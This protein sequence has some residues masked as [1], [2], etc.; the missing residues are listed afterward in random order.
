MIQWT[1]NTQSSVD[2]LLKIFQERGGRINRYYL[3]EWNKN[4]HTV[5]FLNGWFGGRNI[6]EALT[7]ALA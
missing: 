2:E 6:R 1:I 3:G 7:R 4:K 5:V